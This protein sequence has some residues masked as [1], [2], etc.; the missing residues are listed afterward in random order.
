M[1]FESCAVLFQ[2]RS[3]MG[4]YGSSVA[5][6]GLLHS[7]SQQVAVGFRPLH[8][9][10]WLL[11]S[12]KVRQSMVIRVKSTVAHKQI[13]LGLS[14][15]A[16]FCFVLEYVLI[17]MAQDKKNKM[18]ILI[19]SQNKQLMAIAVWHIYLIAKNC[20]KCLALKMIKGKLTVIRKWSIQWRG[21]GVCHSDVPRNQL[22]HQ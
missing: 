6:R 8:K 12:K 18:K 7:N 21:G 5:T 16:L 13:K 11:V 20:H 9:P 15:V 10:N 4:D 2:S 22:K 19:E 1:C 3:T 17:R 14:G